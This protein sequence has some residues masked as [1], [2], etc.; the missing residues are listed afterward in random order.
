MQPPA[1]RAPKPT[2]PPAREEHDREAAGREL[3]VEPAVGGV[4]LEPAREQGVREAAQRDAGDQPDPPADDAG[5]RV[6]EAAG[7][8]EAAVAGGQQQHDR[9]ADGGTG[10]VPGELIAHRR[11]SASSSRMRSLGRP[12]MA[13]SPRTTTGRCSSAGRRA[14]SSITGSRST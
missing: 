3:A 11:Q 10:G 13:R 14:S 4:R 6:G 8:A 12:M 5:E 2:R 1:V 9:E 7:D